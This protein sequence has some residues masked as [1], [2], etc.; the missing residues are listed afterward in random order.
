MTDNFSG[1]FEIIVHK[2]GLILIHN[3]SQTYSIF[4]VRDHELQR[5][6]INK[7]KKEDAE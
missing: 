7:I 5:I 6:Y 4:E 1:D 3:P 2:R